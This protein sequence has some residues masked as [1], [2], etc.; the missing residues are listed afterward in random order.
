[1]A[2]NR[3][4]TPDIECALNLDTGRFGKTKEPEDGIGE[5]Q[6]DLCLA[7]RVLEQSLRC[8][9][10]RLDSRS[11]AG[12]EMHSW[13]RTAGYTGSGGVWRAMRLI[14]LAV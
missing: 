1:M 2:I 13:K 10:V 6:D 12:R 8:S 7:E 14:Y 3:F 4:R 11:D 5:A 9:A